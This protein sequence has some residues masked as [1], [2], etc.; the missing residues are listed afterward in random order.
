MKKVE[1][2]GVKL[3]E[4]SLEDLRKLITKMIDV[5][6]EKKLSKNSKQMSNTKIIDKR[7]VKKQE[8]LKKKGND[9]LVLRIK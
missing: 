4:C 1:K 6:L 9:V 5:E 3:K 8:T 7:K 2:K